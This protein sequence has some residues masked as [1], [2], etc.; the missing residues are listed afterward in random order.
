[1]NILNFMDK[2]D[3]MTNTELTEGEEDSE[4]DSED[5]SDDKAYKNF[6]NFVST[7]A[8][9]NADLK[10]YLFDIVGWYN[11]IDT[12][13]LDEVSIRN[14]YSLLDEEGQK[15]M[16]NNYLPIIRKITGVQNIN[17]IEGGKRRKSLRKS[18]SK[19]K[20]KRRKSLRKKRY[21]KSKSNK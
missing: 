20:S 1:M 19:T 18:K 5:D 11:M 2:Q 13:Y 16:I 9:D 14:I 3:I 7:Q 6:Y 15:T 21:R 4:D 10:D 12:H 17:L 8:Q